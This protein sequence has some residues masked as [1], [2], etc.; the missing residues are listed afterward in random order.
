M[1]RRALP[2]LLSLLAAIP[3]WAPA[4]A[5]DPQSFPLT[6]DTPQYCAQLA[7]QITDRKSTMPD[8]ERLLSEGTDMCGRGQI[9]GGIRRLRRAL[10]ILHH[11]KPAKDQSPRTAAPKDGPAKAQPAKP[12]PPAPKTAD[13]P[14]APPG[15]ARP[16]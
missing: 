13:M 2:L 14:P 10:V 12:A 8:V 6:T 1:T 16:P 4:R 15:P 5:E 9:R 11:H 7:K 3:A